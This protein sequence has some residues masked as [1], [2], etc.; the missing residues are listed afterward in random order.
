MKFELRHRASGCV[1]FALET[2]SLRLC[3]EAAIRSRASLSSANL[4]GADLSYANLSHTDL[5]GANLSG[6]DLSGANLSGANLSGANLSGAKGAAAVIAK[7]RILPAGDI[8][9]WKAVRTPRGTGI[10][11]LLIPASAKRS[12]ALGRKCRAEYAD[13]L[14]APEGAYTN[15]HGPRTEYVVGQ[16]AMP[17]GW[18]E[19]W[20]NECSQGIHFF[21]TREEAEEWEQ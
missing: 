2:E 19:D 13:V 14:E 11:K 20:K 3:V 7:T 21:I 16:R 17:N 4:P 15:A 5:S 9:G 1:L 18:D 12:H 6:A 10:V 8:I